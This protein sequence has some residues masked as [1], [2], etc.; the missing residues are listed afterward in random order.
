MSN[1]QQL[2]HSCINYNTWVVF[3]SQCHC[4]LI[5]NLVGSKAH[6]SL[7]YVVVVLPIQNKIYLILSFPCPKKNKPQNNLIRKQKE[8]KSKFSIVFGRSVGWNTGKSRWSCGQ[9]ARTESRDMFV[10][11][12]VMNI[13]LLSQALLWI[14]HFAASANDTDTA[15]GSY[16]S[17]TSVSHGVYTLMTSE[18]WSSPAN[19]LRKQSVLL[20]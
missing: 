14:P 5:V 8:A 2:Q 6:Q 20:T 17:V 12:F 18:L 16:I 13:T 3:L 19:R 1:D 11:T 10:N 4:S 15:I 7:C 9:Q